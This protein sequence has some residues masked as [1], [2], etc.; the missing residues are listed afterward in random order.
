MK[1]IITMFAESVIYN[2]ELSPIE[3]LKLIY[4]LISQKDF[5]AADYPFIHNIP[6][7]QKL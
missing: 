7:I 1:E 6:E 4:R 5:L 3:K 2:S